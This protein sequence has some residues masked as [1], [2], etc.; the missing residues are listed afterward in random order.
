VTGQ[1]CRRHHLSAAEADDFRSDV[2]FHFIDR[3]YEVLRRFEGRCSLPTYINVVVQRVFLDFR[4]REWG[5]WR[6]SAQAKRQGSQAILLERLASRDGWTFDQIA[7]MLR[8]NHGIV[9]DEPLRMFYEQAIARSPRPKLVAEDEAGRVES[10]APGA[11]TNVV[12]A[13]QGFLAKRVRVALIR[14]QQALAAE[15]R[16]ILK[17]R[18]E[19]AVSVADIARALHLDQKRLYRTIERLLRRIASSLEMEGI[20][21]ADAAALF[22]QGALSWDFAP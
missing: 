17:M 22:E 19:D 8:V 11:D 6:P 21:R 5:R 9:I 1:V 3:E 13:E 18:F 16:L 2:R 14:A 20:S 12:R 10:A 7:E 4:N 15:E